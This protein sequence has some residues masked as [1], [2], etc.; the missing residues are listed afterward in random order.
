MSAV[1][2]LSAYTAGAV[3]MI[4]PIAAGQV[5]IGNRRA[6]IGSVNKLA[7]AGVN[8]HMGNAVGTGAG[9]ENNVTGL[10][11][12]F[13][14]IGTHLI[15]GSGCPVRG[16]ANLLQNVVHQSGTVKSIGRCAAAEIPG[17]E[18]LFGFRQNV[19]ATHSRYSCR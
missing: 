14:N 9:E 2:I 3:I 4:G 17:T 10:Q 5:G 12:A 7:A 16:E 6:G 8:T 15:L 18:M 1:N 11:A 19:R 13:F